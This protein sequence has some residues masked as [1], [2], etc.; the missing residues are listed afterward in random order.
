[1]SKEMRAALDTLAVLHERDLDIHRSR[2]HSG[3][4]CG[5]V[6]MTHDYRGGRIHAMMQNAVA[7]VLSRRVSP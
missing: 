1:M 5:P 3:R 6:C 4:T 7:P 2:F